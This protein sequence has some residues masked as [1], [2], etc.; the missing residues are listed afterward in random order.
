MPLPLFI[1]TLLKKIED[2]PLILFPIFTGCGSGI[3]AII[4]QF[5][6]STHPFIVFGLVFII[7]FSMIVYQ[8]MSCDIK[9]KALKS[10]KEH[11]KKVKDLYADGSIPSNVFEERMTT[12]EK[13]EDG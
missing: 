7:A 8:F 12:L 9:I 2:N 11:Y 13:Y 6:I 10:Q 1:Q 3:L 4:S 5:V